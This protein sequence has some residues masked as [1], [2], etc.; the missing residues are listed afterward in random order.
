MKKSL[1][2][3]M[4]L[5]VSYPVIAESAS[6]KNWIDNTLEYF[7]SSDKIDVSQ[8]IDWGVLPG[9]F[10]NPE[11]GVG[12]G[13]AAVGLYAPYDWV[14]TTP[15]STLAIKSYFSSTGSYGLGVENR[16]YFNQ[17][18]F[19][20][21]A[22]VWISHK[23]QYY[24]GVG[25]DNAEKDER[26]TE[27]EGK[28]FKVHP[29]LAYQ[30]LPN[31]YLNLGWDFQA[32]N[33]QQIDVPL[34]S[35]KELKDQNISG[36]TVGFEYDSRDFEP[37]PYKGKLLLAE[38]SQ[39]KKVLGSNYNY[40]RFVFN[41]RQYLQLNEKNLLAWDFYGEK[42]AGDIPWYGYAELGDDDRMRGY[43]TGQYRDRYYLAAQLELRH[44]FNARHG[45]VGWLG[46]GNIAPHARTLFNN[47]WLPTA[48]LGY[49]FAFKPRIN[50]RVDFAYGKSGN[51]S[52]YFNINEAF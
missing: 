13:A 45:M 5:S 22:D 3:F 32:Y 38:W 41:Y 50:V 7:G 26:K 20:V 16:T 51:Q 15:Y 21:L 35:I 34:L 44:Q 9:P 40:Q 10:A 11:Q 36:L 52:V 14:E 12:I 33:H 37:N 42:V 27:Y 30:F 47:D 24:W 48:G 43:Y 28:I 46:A 17:D 4:A 29:K 6:Q 39:Y 31:T 25:R 49:R 8:G 1:A 19:R 23:P 2:V 18:K